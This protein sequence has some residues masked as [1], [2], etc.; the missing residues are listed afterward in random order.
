MKIVH[1]YPNPCEYA[2][3]LYNDPQK[4]PDLFDAE[5]MRYTDLEVRYLAGL[6]ELGHDCVLFYPR[7]IRVSVKE[8]KHIKGYRLKRFP[9]SIRFG[10][11]NYPLKML[12]ALFKER[13]DVVHY[14]GIYGG[15]KYFHIR[16]YVIVA[17]FCRLYRIPFFG[18]YHTGSLRVIPKIEALRKKSNFFRKLESFIRLF[19]FNISRG[20]T[21]INHLELERLFNP[22]FDEFY[23]VTLKT[24]FKMVTPNTISRSSFYPI[25][26]KEAK[27]KIHLEEK[28]RYLLFVSRIIESKGLHD[29]LAVFPAV[30]SKYPDIILL[31]VGDYLDG[32]NDYEQQLEK[33]IKEKQLSDYIRFA[34]RVEHHCGLH[35]YYNAAE[36]FLLPTY[37]ES[38]GAVNIEALACG[39]PVISSNIEEI[40]YYM[41]SKMG[42]LIEPG[43][44]KEL[45][46]AI[47]RVISGDFKFDRKY[48]LQKM[49]KY[50]YQKCAKKLE[51]FY[52][53][54]IKNRK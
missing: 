6:Q 4:D 12:W 15:G 27:K 30:I 19:P 31:V 32:K 21:S 47:D 40:P 49:Q 10:S 38:F 7:N 3:P 50:W 33:I 42:I 39:I 23:G 48:T 29:I 36:V 46:S 13:P 14:H 2:Y 24:P 8:F 20:L 51:F 44:R 25:A 17:V 53:E 9:V 52:A 5:I 35:Y 26:K 16:F 54:A 18:F 28:K 37:T 43:N 41:D 22:E 1:I 45:F 34:S 11:V